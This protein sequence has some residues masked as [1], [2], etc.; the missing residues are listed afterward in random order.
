MTSDIAQ[1]RQYREINPLL[2][3][4]GPGESSS[5]PSITFVRISPSPPP[6]CLSAP[7][8]SVSRPARG[9]GESDGELA[10]ALAAEHAYETEGASASKPAFLQEL[11][12]EGVWSVS[13]TANAD[14]VVI[15]R[16]FGDETCAHQRAR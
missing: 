2:S 15:S 14:D 3:H 10:S 8:F 1:A 5:S 7:S 13:D 11:E 9:A 4:G 12:A 16:K 6:P